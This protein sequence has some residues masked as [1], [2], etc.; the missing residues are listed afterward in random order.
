LTQLVND[1][2]AL[3]IQLA[4]NMSV[5]LFW[6]SHH[7]I[8]YLEKTSTVIFLYLLWS[9]HHC[10]SYLEKISTVILPPCCNPEVNSEQELQDVGLGS[11]SDAGAIRIVCSCQQHSLLLHFY[12]RCRSRSRKLTAFIDA[13]ATAAA[14]AAAS[15]AFAAVTV[16]VV[17]TPAVMAVLDAVVAAAAAAAA[18]SSQV[19][20][21]RLTQLL[22]AIWQHPIEK[23]VVTISG[24]VPCTAGVADVRLLPW[25][26]KVLCSVKSAGVGRPWHQGDLA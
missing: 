25:D 3:R 2:L 20:I 12:R 24:E 21:L 15:V 26:A 9:S 8:S 7:C 4:N 1:D 19:E 16:A 10:I 14:A 5:P 11:T 18:A 22:Q 23:A 17:T 6:S 13:A